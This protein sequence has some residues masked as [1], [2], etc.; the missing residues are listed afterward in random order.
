LLAV[1]GPAGR[2]FRKEH[3][4][5]LGLGRIEQNFE[6]GV[7]A[8]RRLTDPKAQRE[9]GIRLLDEAMAELNR[10]AAEVAGTAPKDTE[11]K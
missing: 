3:G 4:A 6:D 7:A 5:T 9:E 1:G 8:A 2:T 11:D 10:L